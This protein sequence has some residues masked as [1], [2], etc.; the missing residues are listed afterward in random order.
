MKALFL[1]T[2]IFLSGIFAPTHDIPIAVFH[3]TASDDILELDITFD[4]EDLSESL[5]MM[6]RD[7]N[8]KSIQEYLNENTVFQFNAQVTSLEISEVQI[9]RDHIKIKGN[10]GIT[11]KHI[12]IIK[13]ENT[14]LNNISHHSNVIRIDLNNKSRDFRMHDKRTVITLNY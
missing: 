5:G 12:D 8:L 6:T 14:C 7:I 1:I 4:L 13:I 11:T 2:T 10:F 9:V 3:I